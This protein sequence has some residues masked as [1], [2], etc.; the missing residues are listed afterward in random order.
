[1]EQIFERLGLTFGSTERVE[2]QELLASVIPDLEAAL[3]AWVIQKRTNCDGR[4]A[5]RVYSDLLDEVVATKKASLP[6]RAGRVRSWQPE[7]HAAL[8]ARFNAI[9][10]EEKSRGVKAHAVAAVERL[11]GELTR[12]DVPA[13]GQRHIEPDSLL[14]RL[15]RAR[16]ESGRRRTQ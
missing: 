3:K 1:M 8:L 9:N 12:G 13:I 6:S 16:M 10:A 5:A 4:I 14:K 15:R 7:Q 11:C 2:L